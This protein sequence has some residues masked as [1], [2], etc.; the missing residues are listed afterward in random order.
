MSKNKYDPD[1]AGHRAIA[2]KIVEKRDQLS[3]S[4]KSDLAAAMNGGNLA[5]AQEI[6]RGK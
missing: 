1:N 4:E 2:A 3:S 6:L 5:K